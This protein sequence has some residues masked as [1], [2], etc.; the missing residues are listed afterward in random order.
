MVART[1]SFLLGENELAPRS[2]TAGRRPGAVA[3]GDNTH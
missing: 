2:L 1:R 3:D